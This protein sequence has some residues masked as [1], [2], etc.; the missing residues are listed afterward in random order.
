MNNSRDYQEWYTEYLHLD[1]N[2]ADLI[3]KKL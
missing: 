2:S 1:R 3:Y